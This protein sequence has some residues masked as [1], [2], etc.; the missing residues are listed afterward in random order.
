MLQAVGAA[1]SRHN[2]DRT[3]STSSDWCTGLWAHR[4]VGHQAVAHPA[5]C[6]WGS[7]QVEHWARLSVILLD[8]PHPY[9]HLHLAAVVTSFIKVKFSIIGS[10]RCV[11]LQC[12]MWAVRLLGEVCAALVCYERRVIAKSLEII[13]NVSHTLSPQ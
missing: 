11:D 3:G 6:S 9:P 1:G 2:C 7:R 13:A 12:L 5:V 8:N 4:A 10:L